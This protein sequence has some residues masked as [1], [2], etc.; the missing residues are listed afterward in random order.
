M[1]HGPQLEADHAVGGIVL[2]G[3]VHVRT[4]RGDVLLVEG[5]PHLRRKLRVHHAAHIHDCF[6]V[7]F[8]AEVGEPLGI[9]LFLVVVPSGDGRALKHHPGAVGGVPRHERQHHALGHD[10][11]CV[12]VTGTEHGVAVHVDAFLAKVARLLAV[13]DH[14]CQ[15]LRALTAPLRIGRI[16]MKAVPVVARGLAKG[17]GVREIRVVGTVALSSERWEDGEGLGGE[18]AECER[19][20][21]GSGH[22]IQ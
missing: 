4:C 13:L 11:L 8:D 2:L 5:H 18:R 20:Q 1:L 3:R 16:A 17:T 9:L 14:A 19:R 6:L 12:N 7:C 15:I 22:C 21:R 10:Q